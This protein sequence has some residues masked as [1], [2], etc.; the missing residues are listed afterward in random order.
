MAALHPTATEIESARAN[1]ALV[2]DWLAHA[3]EH[4]PGEHAPLAVAG[5]LGQVESVLGRLL[6][7]QQL[8]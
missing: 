5:L 6:E 1:V 3:A 8:A 7:A 2:N 4:G